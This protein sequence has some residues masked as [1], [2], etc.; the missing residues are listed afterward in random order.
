MRRRQNFL[1]S[2]TKIWVTMHFSH[3]F[4]FFFAF[5]RNNIAYS[6]ISRHAPSLTCSAFLRLGNEGKGGT[7]PLRDFKSIEAIAMKTGVYSVRSTFKIVSFN[8]CKMGRQRQA[9]RERRHR[10]FTAAI[11]DPPCWISHFFKSSETIQIDRKIINSN[12]KEVLKCYECKS[13]KQKYTHK[14][15]LQA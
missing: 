5:V 12:K 14:R 2:K 9:V 11:L 7:L 4:F 6:F 15:G 10:F 13:N 1:A 8:I 3:F